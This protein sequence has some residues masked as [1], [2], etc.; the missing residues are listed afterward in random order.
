[1]IQHTRAL[2]MTGDIPLR[3]QEIAMADWLENMSDDVRS[4]LDAMPFMVLLMDDELRIHDANR[5]AARM[6]GAE[7]RDLSQQ[8]P[9]GVLHCLNARSSEGGCGSSA[10]CADC[11]IRNSVL[12]AGQRREVFRQA[13]RMRLQVGG[14]D[15]DVWYAVTASPFPYRRLGAYLVMLEDISELVI[16]RSIIPICAQCRKIRNEGNVWEHADS[17]L[18]KR[19]P[20][21]FSHG[22]CPDCMKELYPHYRPLHDALRD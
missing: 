17:Y 19:T 15:R 13:S 8:R 4:V 16:L 2:V 9:G 1:M 21:E 22:L 14:K 5:A 12:Q 20:L 10:S 6:L 18:S 3:E 11:V 7:P